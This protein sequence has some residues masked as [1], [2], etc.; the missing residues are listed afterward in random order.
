MPLPHVPPHVQR[1]SSRPPLGIRLSV[2]LTVAAALGGY[3]LAL[4]L[5]GVP[6]LVAALGGLIAGSVLVG[7]L[8]D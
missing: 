8:T 3:A 1:R 4:G 2:S 5:T 7:A 6:V